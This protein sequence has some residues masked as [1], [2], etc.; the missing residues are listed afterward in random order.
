M[1][2]PRALQPGAQKRASFFRA[3]AHSGLSWNCG[4]GKRRGIS[5][6]HT[7]RIPRFMLTHLNTCP[8]ALY[9]TKRQRS[10]SLHFKVPW[11]LPRNYVRSGFPPCSC[12]GSYHCASRASSKRQPSG[13]LC[14]LAEPDQ[15]ACQNSQKCWKCEAI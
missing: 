8:T 2:T 9:W 10:T 13:L 12:L 14:F 4:L 3:G 1:C 6:I 15:G 11:P 5:P 7:C